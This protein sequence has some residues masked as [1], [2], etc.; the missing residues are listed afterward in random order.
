MSMKPVQIWQAA[1][2]ELSMQ[3]SAATYNAFIRR[4]YVTQHDPTGIITIVVESDSIKMW[5]EKNLSKTIDRILTGIVGSPYH[6]E[7]VV[8]KP[9]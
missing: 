1:Q 7:F 5:W 6:A 3:I 8:G 4:T 2:G 9:N